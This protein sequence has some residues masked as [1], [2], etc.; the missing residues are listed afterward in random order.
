MLKKLRLRNYLLMKEAEVE[1]DPHL[2]I[3]TGETGAGKSI[4]V[5][6]IQYL[7][8]KRITRPFP[9][10][11]NEKTMIEGIFQ[12]SDLPSVQK[13]LVDLGYAEREEDEIVIYR[14]ILAN[15]RSRAFLNDAPI[16]LQLVQEWLGP[17]VDIHSQ[18]ETQLLLK[19]SYQ[20]EILDIYAE[21]EALLRSFQ[22]LYQQYQ[23]K[24]NLLQR[25]I[26]EV[27]A[28]KKEQEFL[29]YQ[30]QELSAIPLEELDEEAI[31]EEWQLLRNVQEIGAKLG[32]VYH[33]LYESDHAVVNRFASLGHLLQSLQ[34]K[35]SK[36]ESLL[37]E[38]NAILSRLQEISRELQGY[39]F[40]LEENPERLHELT[41]LINRIH[42][43]KLKYRVTALSDLIQRKREVET[44]L[45]T[46]Q[47][48]SG[49][50]TQLRQEVIAM[51]QQL[52]D[53]AVELEE[54]RK[55]AAKQLE[56]KIMDRFKRIKLEKARFQIHIERIED[57][58][59]PF[60]I[61]EKGYR[62]HSRGFNKVTFFV[63]MN[64]GLG[65]APLSEVAS[66]GEQARLMLALKAALAEKLQSR[67]LIFDEIDT[68]ISG[69][70][71]LRVGE[72]LESL[73]SYRQVILITH[74]PQVAS[75]RGTH[76][77]VRKIQEDKATSTFIQPL[78]GEERIVEIAKMLSG[79]V[80]EAALQNA[81]NLLSS[82][83]A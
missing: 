41:Q 20:L 33:E 25:T 23:E 11:Q 67:L 45:Q 51:R 50:V 1:F 6:A 28:I 36:V 29:T 27:E 69:E 2:N 31:Q 58:E 14:E 74:T 5:E 42:E 63:E 80:T 46:L 40:S 59:S 48:S 43:L 79:T 56:A 34:T 77:S 68:G 54:R 13:K 8:G 62:M 75:R 53:L 52:L 21:V 57:P 4:F 24:A 76:F 72:L 66:G 9:L 82:Q 26:D 22:S 70:T 44:K 3:I 64:P 73:A 47:V 17:Y 12:I 78:S 19:S 32:E 65:F 55:E 18:Q 16:Q 81:K 15:Q 10:S 71:A 38:W 60:R 30:W 61:G 35:F 39:L 37:Q 83:M 49:M 7:L